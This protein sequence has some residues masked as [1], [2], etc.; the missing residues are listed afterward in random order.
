MSS[1]KGEIPIPYILAIVLV[2]IVLGLLA[3]WLYTGGKGW[4][5][6]VS[7]STCRAKLKFY[8]NSWKVNTYAAD[9][10]PNGVTDFSDDC[11]TVNQIENKDKYYAPD[12]C[13]LTWAQDVG[14]PTCEQ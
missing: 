1:R 14:Q 9:K 10:K 3:Y 4:D 2:V 8:C 13:A 6:I 5:Q 11:N 7:E 12:C